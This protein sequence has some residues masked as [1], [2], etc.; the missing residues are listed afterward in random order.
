MSSSLIAQIGLSALDCPLLAERLV[1]GTQRGDATRSL[2]RRLAAHL[3]RIR[4]A[5]ISDQPIVFTGRIPHL[6][7]DAGGCDPG[8]L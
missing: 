4:Q 8:S 2:R 6:Q 1:Y 3:H 7:A 5:P